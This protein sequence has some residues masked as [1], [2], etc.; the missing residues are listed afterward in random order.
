MP[1]AAA[2]ALKTNPQIMWVRP[3]GQADQL[4]HWRSPSV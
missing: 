4:V 2:S 1:D 3:Y